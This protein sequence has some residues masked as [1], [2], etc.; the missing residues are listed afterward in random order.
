[1]SVPANAGYAG[2]WKLAPTPLIVADI[3]LTAQSAAIAR[4]VVIA[5]PAMGCYRMSLT[6]G[7]TTLGTSGVLTLSGVGVGSGITVVQSLAGVNIAQATPAWGEFVFEVNGLF[8]GLSYEVTTLSGFT[9]G[10]LQ[11]TARVILEQLSAL[12]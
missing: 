3:R 8:T 9:P 10:S 4:T 11:Y 6:L 7:L 12:P 5:S 1:M 2:P